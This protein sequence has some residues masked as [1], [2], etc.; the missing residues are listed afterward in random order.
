[1]TERFR[2][3]SVQ[4]QVLDAVKVFCFPLGQSLSTFM[5]NAAGL[6]PA[7]SFVTAD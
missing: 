2:L 6:R 5:V 1:M 4:Q 3:D 7:V